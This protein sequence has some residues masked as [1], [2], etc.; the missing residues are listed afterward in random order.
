MGLREVNAARTRELILDAALE[1]F[2]DRGYDATTMEHVA[3]HA[4]IGTSTLYRYF[5]SKDQLVIEPLALQG[6]LSAALLARPEEE[7]L[8]VAL[9]HAVIS[10]IEAPRADQQRLAKIDAAVASSDALQVRLN[11]MFVHV[12][13]ELAEAI[14]ARLGRPG[15]DPYCIATAGLTTLVLELAADPENDATIVLDAEAVVTRARALF[16]SLADEPPTS[17]RLPE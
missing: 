5:P 12:R 3:E 13:R 10:L 7:P 2:V 17:P 15:T 9:G 8:D 14:G 11:E 4:G 16:R 6:H 1:L